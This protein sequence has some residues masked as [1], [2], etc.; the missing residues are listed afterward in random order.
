MNI[1]EILRYKGHDVVTATE[2][3]TVLEAVRVLVEHNI[4]GVVGMADY[5]VTGIL[6]ERDILRLTAG[7]PGDLDSIEVRDAMTRVV[8]A[9]RYVRSSATMALNSGHSV[10]SRKEG[11]TR[12]MTVLWRWRL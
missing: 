5:R 4:G 10:P 9:S 8:M 1:Q 11:A 7:R 6:T 2:S 3:Q 12:S